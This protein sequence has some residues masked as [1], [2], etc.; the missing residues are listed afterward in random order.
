VDRVSRF[1]LL[2]ARLV[3]AEPWLLGLVAGY[4]SIWVKRWEPM[5]RGGLASDL[6]RDDG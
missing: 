6:G 5:L 2:G 1:K 3:D 4:G